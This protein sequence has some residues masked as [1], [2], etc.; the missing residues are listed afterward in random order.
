M[1]SMTNDRCKRY[2]WKNPDRVTSNTICTVPVKYQRSSRGESPGGPMVTYDSSGH[3][4]LIGVIPKWWNIHSGYSLPANRNALPGV[5]VRY[6]IISHHHIIMEHFPRVTSHLEWIKSFA[7]GSI[8]R[9]PRTG[10]G[11]I[12]NAQN[13]QNVQNDKKFLKFWEEGRWS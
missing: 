7:T 8:C 2:R 5:Y 12:L 9:D 11:R 3:A 1:T 13:V 4:T 6:H 10:T